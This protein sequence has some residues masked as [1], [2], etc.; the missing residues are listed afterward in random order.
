[1]GK[2][3]CKQK[4]VWVETVSQL[5]QANLS[6]AMQLRMTLKRSSCLRLLSAEITSIYYHALCAEHGTWASST[7]G[8]YFNSELHIPQ[9]WLFGKIIIQALTL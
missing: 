8:R 9:S 6:S 3:W 1:M 7:L 2:N 4:L 5:A